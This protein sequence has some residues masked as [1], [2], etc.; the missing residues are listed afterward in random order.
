MS[1]NAASDPS[2]R[3][4]LKLLGYMVGTA[5]FFSV[6]LLISFFLVIVSIN[7]IKI[8]AEVAS[9]ILMLGLVPPSVATFLLF[10]KVFGRFI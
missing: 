6:T 4:K 3:D 2:R 9:N 10:T 5:I 7:S 8:P 1:R